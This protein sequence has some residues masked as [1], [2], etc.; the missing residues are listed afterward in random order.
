MLG[1]GVAGVRGRR[2]G[3][4]ERPR[5]SQ[6]MPVD[7]FGILPQQFGLPVQPMRA[8]TCPLDTSI[9]TEECPGTLI[10][11][12]KVLCEALSFDTNRYIIENSVSAAHICWGSIQNQACTG[13]A[14]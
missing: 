6:S 11:A 2:A 13:G 5:A 12:V 1:A 8:S 9:I 4:I 7:I 14:L 10:V 3:P